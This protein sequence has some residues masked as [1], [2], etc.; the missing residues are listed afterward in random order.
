MGD[1]AL[2]YPHLWVRDEAWL[3]AALLYWPRLAR[4]VP[5]ADR[6]T[7]RPYAGSTGDGLSPEETAARLRDEGFLLDLAVD[8]VGDEVAHEFLRLL[9]DHGEE[10]QRRYGIEELARYRGA[11]R[12]PREPAA[13]AR[14]QYIGWMRE[15]KLR[16]SLM[17]RL[18]EAG[19]ALRRPG[20][21]G[22]HPRFAA[23]YLCAVADRLAQ[24]N[25]L[26]AVTDEPELHA[27]LSGWTPGTLAQVLLDDPESTLAGTSGAPAV[28]VEEVGRLF[29]VVAFTVVL[30]DRLEDVPLERILAARRRLGP[31]LYA[32]RRHLETFAERFA[33]VAAVRDPAMLREHLEVTVRGE[34]EPRV[35]ELSRKLRL[36]G[37]QPVRKV[38]GMKAL[39]PAAVM[40]A[41]S[42]SSGLPAVVSA[43]GAVAAC[44]AG[45]AVDARQ[46]ARE[47]AAAS[48]ATYLVGLR[49]A[50]SPRGA[51]SVTRA[52]LRRPAGR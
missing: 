35:D 3:K 7:G 30:P 6:G 10:L 33:E 31:E 21:V 45:A 16:W 50:L 41:V 40:A 42:A 20:T 19:L 2:Y 32:Y 15:K 9:D 34:I 29:T 26:C 22:M 44:L 14:E 28:P 43:S 12:A 1:L 46:Q 11:G 52:L 8:D 48:P 5:G 38:L 47:A 36:L 27:A 24:R 49:D 39:A 23:A 37:L 13:Q 18:E 51:V 25:A 4:M 17:R